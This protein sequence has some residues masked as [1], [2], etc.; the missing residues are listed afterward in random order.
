[1][2]QALAAGVLGAVAVAACAPGPAQV[3]R[4]FFDANCVAC[5]GA[6][7]RGGPAAAG[8]SRPVPDLSRIAARNDGAFDRN[9]VMSTIDGY[10][11][12]GDPDHPMPEFGA[13]MDGRLVMVETEPGVFTPTPEVL[14]GLVDYLEGLQR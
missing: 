14:V 2:R 9:A 13:T 1:M 6:D 12:R 11:R 3:G 5:H 7:G 10:Y 8:L 4:A